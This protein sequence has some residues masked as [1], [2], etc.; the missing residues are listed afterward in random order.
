MV[1]H[2]GGYMIHDETNQLG[3]VLRKI[4]LARKSYKNLQEE[5]G[6]TLDALTQKPPE[7]KRIVKILLEEPILIPGVSLVMFVSF[8]ARRIP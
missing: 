4:L 2:E 5:Y 8:L 3:T 6:Q 1:D 7:R